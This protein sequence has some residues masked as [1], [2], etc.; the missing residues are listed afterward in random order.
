MKKLV[1]SDFE[2]DLSSYDVTTM[3]ENFWFTDRIFVKR[4]LPFEITLTSDIDKVL[5]YISFPN[6]RTIETMFNGY[7]FEKNEKFTAIFEVEEFESSLSVSIVFGFDEFPNFSKR[8]SELPLDKFEVDNIYTHAAGIISQ[9]WP[10]VNYNFPQIHTD[11]INTEEEI[12]FAFGKI[13]NNYKDGAFL[14]NEVDITEDITYNRNIMQPLPY[15]LH[16]LKKGFEDAGYELEGDV[17]S[18][19]SIKKIC[20]YSDVEYYTTNE[21]EPINIF[22]MSEDFTDT[23]EIT[24]IRPPYI[25]RMQYYRFD[26]TYPIE[27][28]GK[29]RIV[30]TV[31]MK[32]FP[33]LGPRPFFRIKYRNQVLFYHEV[34]LDFASSRFTITKN[35]DVVFETL[36][37]ILPNEII[38]E[39]YQ[40]ASAD[41][42]IISLDIN[43]IR[44]HD[45]S[46]EAVPTIINPNQVDLS[47]SVPEMTFGE[48][49]TTLKNW[50]NLDLTPKGNKA[51]VNFVQ[52]EI[53][54]GEVIDLSDTEVKQPRR[55]FNKGVSFLLQFNE[56]DSKDYT[57]LPVFHSAS[58]ITN[59]SFVKNEKT[60]EIMINALP[61]PLMLR[62]NVQT[63][64]HFDSDTS[65]LF[66][67]MYDGLTSGLNLAKNPDEIM[68]PKVHERHFKEWFERRINSQNFIWEFKKYYENIRGLNSKKKIFAYNQ[69]HLI[70]NINKN[71]LDE[72]YY[73]IEIETEASLK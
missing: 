66:A 62:E 19:E 25:H 59:N 69:I 50:F 40:G 63:A 22:K 3:E 2:L 71:E 11:K 14:I 15:L 48:F 5:G 70:K 26:F 65:K 44:L 17:L 64:H 42:I 61:L 30:G 9:T 60:N 28:P 8:L 39:S 31:K 7:Y 51:I 36:V 54:R 72:N 53:K 49:F 24:L 21:Q 68:I 29:Y 38:L 43:P 12:W 47:R 16:I 33:Y 52:D 58:G 27:H 6:S 73:E 23:G 4:T 32:L 67:V 56:T 20:I 45:T 41:E 13:I 35:V 18:D 1:C 57:F 10:V 34:N 37:D 46:G 55:K